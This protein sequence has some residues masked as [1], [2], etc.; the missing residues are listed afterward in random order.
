LSSFHP[1]AKAPT[2][3]KMPSRFNNIFGKAEEFRRFRP[4]GAKATAGH[5]IFW[6]SLKARRLSTAYLYWVDKPE[7]DPLHEQPLLLV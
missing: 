1:S 4:F 2:S 6:K 7:S 3:N 5:F